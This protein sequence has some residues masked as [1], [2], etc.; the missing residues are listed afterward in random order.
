MDEKNN[1]HSF[2]EIPALSLILNTNLYEVKWFISNICVFLHTTG[3]S[4][5][6]K[7]INLD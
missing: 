4:Q 5:I 7:Y 6:L 3:V 1:N 2:T